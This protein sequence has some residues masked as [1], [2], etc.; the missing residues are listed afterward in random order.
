MVWKLR[1]R[2]LAHAHPDFHVLCLLMGNFSKHF[3]G[4]EI[5]PPAAGFGPLAQASMG[6]PDV[7]FEVIISGTTDRRTLDGDGALAVS[8]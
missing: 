4:G 6:R 8:H 1:A 7:E 5:I 3:T 2:E